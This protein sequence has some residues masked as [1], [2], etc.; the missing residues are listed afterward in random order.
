MKLGPIVDRVARGASSITLLSSVTVM[1]LTTVTGVL[2]A[3]LLSVG[4]RGTLSA[5]LAV[6]SV[7]SFV[8]VAGATEALVLAPRRGVDE[9]SVGTI[10]WLWSLLIGASSSG[11]VVVYLHTVGSPSALF[12]YLACL[13]PLFGTF[14]ALTN[15]ELVRLRRYR[16]AAMLRLS[17][18][19]VQVCVIVVLAISH[20]ATLTTLML[21]SVVGSAVAG[22][23][24]LVV[25]PPRRRWRVGGVRMSEVAVVRKVGAQTGYA[26]LA[27]ALSAR[28][29]LVIVS[30]LIGSTASGLLSV[31]ASLSVAA[32]SLIGSLAPV[33]LS[34]G[35]HANAAAVA[36]ASALSWAMALFIACVGPVLVPIVYGEEY[37]GLLTMLAFIA[38]ATLVSTHFELLSRLLQ[39]AAMESL[40][41]RATL[42]A[43]FVQAV[44]VVAVSL[45]GSVYFVPVG[46][47]AGYA[48]AFVMLLIG[49]GG[50]DGRNSAR[51]LNPVLYLRNVLKARSWFVRG[52]C[53][54][55][56]QKVSDGVR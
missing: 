46:T 19:V 4:D 45:W 43:L 29:D 21:A 1:L 36:T 2:S 17:P 40:V 7:L 42:L 52:Q 35:E 37:S 10:T 53:I 20:R 9:R 34:R 18:L 39:S 44:L 48:L 3:R 47:L 25:I 30:V 56:G 31:A 26:Q 51:M 27:R 12:T 6:T 16:A 38:G 28:C 5:T 41:W 54:E 13:T 22:L 11:I 55:E 49:R 14:G 32:T 24:S 8:A 23:V 33:L 15:F 50:V